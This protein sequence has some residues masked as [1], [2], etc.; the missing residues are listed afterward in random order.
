MSTE[1]GT[2]ATA[3]PAA[4]ARRGRV[5]FAAVAAQSIEYYDFLIYGTAASLILNTLFFPSESTLAST[6]ASFATFAVGF[7]GRP[8]GAALFGHFGDKF[9]R[10]PALLAAMLLMAVSSTLIGLLPTYGTIGMGAPIL[11]VVLRIAQGISVGGHFGGAT[12]LALESAPPNRR[13][14]F[15]ALPQIGVA[16]GMITGT[17][18]FLLVSSLTTDDQFSS[19]GWR[20]PFLL[21]IVMF[22]VAYFVHRYVEDTQ[23]YH[24]AEANASARKG[25]VPRSSVLQ[26]LRRPKQLLL[27]AF[28]FL[29]ATISFYGIV[30]GLLHY[31]TDDLKISKDTML[32]VV[33]L[34]M[35]AFTA[36]TIGFAWLSD[37]LDRRKVYAGNALFFG[38]WAFAMFPL[39]ET[40]SFPLI[41]VSASVGLLACGGM[42]GP[43]TALL[44]EAFPAGMRYSGSSLGNQ[45]ANILGA[46]LAPF[47]MVALVAATDTTVSVSAYMAASCVISLF[48]VAMLKIPARES[49]EEASR[50]RA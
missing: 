43:G 34:S 32:T 49:A 7:A 20:I 25:S 38:A 4:T 15:G 33:M 10:K 39:V 8:I 2:Q 42:F 47:I 23:E 16:V 30:A 26:V 19:W 14:L 3:T 22:P 18:V 5:L 6:L 21:S 17:L 44:A 41:L 45:L 50:D 1:T 35:I 46:G 27:V 9:G 13:G 12:L 36:G 28:T 37:V 31:A 11:L 48:A 24:Q 40:R 29:P